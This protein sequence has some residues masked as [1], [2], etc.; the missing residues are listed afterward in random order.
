MLAGNTADVFF[1]AIF[2]SLTLGVLYKFAAIDAM[3]YAA[4]A[5][6]SYTAL[7]EA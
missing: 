4:G 1:E 3:R 2:N 5:E 6:A 7:A